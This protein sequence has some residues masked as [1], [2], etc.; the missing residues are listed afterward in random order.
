MKRVKKWWDHLFWKYT[1]T[2]AKMSHL[3]A[4]RYREY[5]T[6]SYNESEQIKILREFHKELIDYRQ[7]QI[8]NQIVKI[9]Q[10][11]DRQKEL[12]SNLLKL[13]SAI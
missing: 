8:S 13:T 12:E 11:Q 4:K 6:N 7:N 1:S 9:V 2:S 10:E 5:I 3:E